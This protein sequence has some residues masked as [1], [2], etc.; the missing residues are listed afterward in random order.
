MNVVFG[1]TTGDLLRFCELLLTNV[2]SDGAVSMSLPSGTYQ[3]S[4]GAD[5]VSKGNNHFCFA[6]YARN[7]WIVTKTV[8]AEASA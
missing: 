4:D 7:C 8:V 3:F 2:E 5:T 6:E 1:A